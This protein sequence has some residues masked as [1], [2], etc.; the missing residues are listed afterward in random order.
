[1]NELIGFSRKRG[2]VFGEV[3]LAK[4]ILAYLVKKFHDPFGTIR[5]I[6][7]FKRAHY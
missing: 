4:L 1:M 3:L 6:A 7:A 2:N 5:F